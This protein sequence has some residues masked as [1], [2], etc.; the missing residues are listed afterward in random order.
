MMI[1]QERPQL[2]RLIPLVDVKRVL[3]LSWPRTMEL[4]RN[5]TLTGYNVSG[6]PVRREE[7][8]DDS[9]GIRVFESELREYIE[10]IRVR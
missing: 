5:G 2:D 6:R 3:A 1:E 8:R 4:V 7:L 9:H 10:S